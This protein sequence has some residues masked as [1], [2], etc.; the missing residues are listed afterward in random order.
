MREAKREEK[1]E[2]EEKLNEISE[3]MGAAV[4]LEQ[5]RSAPLLQRQQEEGE[6]RLI[7][8]DEGGMTEEKRVLMIQASAHWHKMILHANQMK[9]SQKGANEGYQRAQ[10]SMALYPTINTEVAT[11]GGIGEDIADGKDASLSTPNISRV[12]SSPDLKLSPSPKPKIDRQR[13]IQSMGAQFRREELEKIRQEEEEKAKA[14]SP[15]KKSNEKKNSSKRISHSSFHDFE[16]LPPVRIDLKSRTGNSICLVWDVDFEALSA[17][18]FLIDDDGNTLKPLYHVTYRKTHR[19]HHNDSELIGGMY[20]EKKNQWKCACDD[21]EAT[22]IVIK[23]LQPNTSYTFRCCRRNW[24]SKWGPEVNIRTGPGVP[25]CPIDI[26]PSEITSS[27]VLL[28]WLTPEKDNGLPVLGYILR[29]KPFGG[30]FQEIYRGNNRVWI[31]TQLLPYSLYIFEVLAIN[32]AGE[33]LP[34]NRLAIRT[35]PEGATTMTPW[36]EMIDPETQKI[37]FLH[38]KTKAS[39]WS[40]PSGALLDRKKSFQNKM[41]YFYL[42]LKKLSQAATAAGATAGGAGASPHPVHLYLSRENLLEETLRQLRLPTSEELLAGPIRITFQNEVG[43][44]GGGLSREWAVEV[45]KLVIQDTS[46]LMTNSGDDA[47]DNAILDMRAKALHGTDCRWLFISLGKFLGKI[48]IDEL[49]VGI[50]FSD[51][52]LCWIS[53]KLPTLEDLKS[54]DPAMYRGLEW[55]L[56]NPIEETDLTFSASYDLLGTTEIIDFLPNG[57]NVTVTEENKVQ[58]VDLMMAWLIQGRYE[59]ALSHFLTGFHSLIPSTYLEIFHLHEL[60]H[61]LSGEMEIDLNQLMLTTCYTGLLFPATLSSQS[62]DPNDPNSP[63]HVPIIRWFWN[64]LKEMDLEMLP[65]L[66]SFITGC[67]SIPS[68]GLK[69]ALTIT[70]LEEVEEEA[71]EWEGEDGDGQDSPSPSYSSSGRS[72]GRSFGKKNSTLPVAHTCFNQL[73]LPNYDSE[74]VLRERL[75]YAIRN[76]AGQGFHLK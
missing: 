44:D 12:S 19:N 66:L 61:L 18:Q 27:S 76:S 37:F 36:V 40:L 29:M 39:S 47:E 69:P 31:A 6:N 23:D 25:S 3:E 38:P 42:N 17:L 22:M 46:G 1:E 58:Y 56:N 8:G 55:V 14:N 2:K 65:M 49:A 59:P 68:S 70:I 32:R 45:M 72:P 67:S 13:S 15:N 35:L 75:S 50:K 71:R 34:S 57:R 51:L 7:I 11:G 60:Q 73:V 62:V 52:L 63:L 41:K 53:G 20:V 21:Y 33:S 64:I 28:T 48:L 43:I 26:Q 9:Q 4:A 10:E 24:S 54:I 5:S 30:N 74:E 16:N